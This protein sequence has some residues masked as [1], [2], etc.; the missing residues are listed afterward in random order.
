[1]SQSGSP[2]VPDRPAEGTLGTRI[3]VLDDAARFDDATH[4][5]TLRPR[6]GE[7]ATEPSRSRPVRPVVPRWR[8][9]YLVA[10]VLCDL[11]ICALVTI[12]TAGLVAASAV[13]LVTA[14][15]LA[16]GGAYQQRV[17]GQGLDEFRRILLTGT[18]L[19]AL[20]STLTLALD[21]TS[22]R[23][24]VLGSVPLAL[25]GVLCV[26]L[27][28]RFGLRRMRG[29]GRC[30]QRVVAVGLERS[31]AE[32]IRTM[33]RDP[34]S[35]LKIVGA[36]VRNPSLLEIEGVPV[37]GAP[38]EAALVLHDTEADSVLLTAWS[39]VS[40]QDLR[41]LSWAL[42]GTRAHLMVAPRIAEVALPR[43]H[44]RTIA[45]QLLLDIEEPEFT[46]LRRVAKAGL[47]YSLT[48]AGLLAL[49]PVL[50]AVAIAVK[51]DSAGPVLFRQERVGRHG[52]P[53]LMTKFRSMYIDAEARLA[54][55]EH[56][57]EHGGGPLFKIKDD[58]RITRVGRF[59]RRYSLDELPQLFDVLRGTMSLVGP[60]PPLHSEVAL[61]EQDVHR[62]LLVPPGITGLW[63]VSGRSDLSWEESV[64][65][66][67][68]Y[69]ENWSLALDLSIIARTVVAVLGR[70]GAY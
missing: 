34:R 45:G 38:N 67:L 17:L 21:A 2:E 52:K 29:A 5:W 58:P 6:S 15:G 47:D 11:A 51:L 39:D 25:A 59:I 3:D 1:M 8:R 27:G 62:R 66:D 55:L 70:S 69:V 54:E 48:A 4:A 41:R 12:V 49:S 24:V 9:R 43:T 20:I 46:G 60:R 31:V 44:V 53:F 16:L 63:Q 23:S 7:Q 33:H 19:V 18:V 61:Y 28:A 10:L 35:S 65:L 64:R 14:S 37:L 26:H 42:E 56:L 68:S 13:P 40:Q 57:N 32:L 36:C 30:K 50:A 22:M